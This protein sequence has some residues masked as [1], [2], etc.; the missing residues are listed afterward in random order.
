MN[1]RLHKTSNNK[2]YYY[3]AQERENSQHRLRCKR[4]ETGIF[5]IFSFLYRARDYCIKNTIQRNNYR[6]YS[7]PR[8]ASR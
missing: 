2:K 8:K 3:Y 4:N 5:N 1:N 7:L 6:Y